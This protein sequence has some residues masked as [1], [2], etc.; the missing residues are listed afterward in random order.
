M[1]RRGTGKC[2]IC[3]VIL[4]LVAFFSL[5][6]YIIKEL[7]QSDD[8]L[9]IDLEIDKRLINNV[10]TLGSSYWVQHQEYNTVFRRLQLMFNAKAQPKWSKSPAQLYKLVNRVRIPS[11]ILQ[12]KHL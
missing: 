10:K 1:I 12:I 6:F 9:K 5:N 8:N 3:G 2:I 7:N 11:P 4:L